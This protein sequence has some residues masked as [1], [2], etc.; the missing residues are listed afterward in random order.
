MSRWFVRKTWAPCAHH[1]S[2]NSFCF[3]QR[4]SRSRERSPFCSAQRRAAPSLAGSLL[5]R[6]WCSAALPCRGPDGAAGAAAGVGV[7]Q[8]RSLL[9]TAAVPSLPTR[10]AA[11]AS[12]TRDADSCPNTRLVWSG[13]WGG[14]GIVLQHRSAGSAHQQQLLNTATLSLRRYFQHPDRMLFEAKWPPKR[15]QHGQEPPAAAGRASRLHHR[16][17]MDHS[18]IR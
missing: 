10:A 16:T 9:A 8:H 6:S 11:A 7:F 12:R 3:S 15:F 1:T 4:E 13:C 5:C 2:V 18:H 14:L 17:H